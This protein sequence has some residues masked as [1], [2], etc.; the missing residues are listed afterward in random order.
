M[1][2][3]QQVIRKGDFIE[4]SYIA[5]VHDSGIIF[6]LTDEDAAKEHGLFEQGR[7]YT[8]IVICLGKNDILKGLDDA[9]EGKEPGKSYTLTLSPE[10]AFGKKR[11][12]L[13]KLMPT[14]LFREKNIQPMPGLQINLDNL[15]GII[16]SVSG[17]RTIVDFNHPLAGKTILYEINIRRIVHDTKE[18]LS[19]LLG[20][21]LSKFE[22]QIEGEK[23]T[24]LSNLKEAHFEKELEKEILSR[25]PE[26]KQ[27]EFKRLPKEASNEQK[28]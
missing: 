25:V 21:L 15:I 19:G 14:S 5:K 17:G 20:N 18:K 12:E 26:I 24:I 23:A 13:V 1:Q 2:P 6:D 8:P 4:I 22:V 11:T 28:E 10:Q 27:V 16:K 3:Q 7:Q 9:L